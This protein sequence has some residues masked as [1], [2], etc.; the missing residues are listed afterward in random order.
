MG[1]GVRACVSHSNHVVLLAGEWQVKGIFSVRAL[2]GFHGE[3]VPC[4]TWKQQP[5]VLYSHSRCR[6]PS[7]PR[8][9]P[10]LPPSP[11]LSARGLG[12]PTIVKS[13]LT[14]TIVKGHHDEVHSELCLLIELGHD[15]AFPIEMRD[16]ILPAFKRFQRAVGIEFLD[17]GGVLKGRV[18][19][20]LHTGN[21]AL[22]ED[23]AG[24][25]FLVA[26]IP[27]LVRSGTAISL[28]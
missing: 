18:H 20:M 15:L 10:P 19:Q 16:H 7:S 24:A 9:P 8:D 4:I 12:N 3:P 1:D 13:A 14:P 5:H 17:F 23:I 28:W 11:P 26:D 21:Y 22:R 6:K 27:W 25:C 2:I